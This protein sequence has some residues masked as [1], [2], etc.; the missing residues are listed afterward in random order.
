H[1]NEK[2]ANEKQVDEELK[3]ETSVSTSV[4]DYNGNNDRVIEGYSGENKPVWIELGLQTIHERT[5]ERIH[6]GYSL[7]VFEDAWQRL[8]GRGLEGILHV[9]LG[10]PGETRTD[11]LETM[12]YIAELNPLPDGIKLQQLQILRGTAL[13]QEYLRE[14]FPVM[15]LDEYCGLIQECLAILPPQIVIHRLTGDGPKSLLIAPSWSADKK[16]VLNTMQHILA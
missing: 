13:G 4:S 9:I 2:H 7:P 1:A 8:K 11:M 3:N 15:T 6:R 10:L 5:A 14:P 16:R 12:R